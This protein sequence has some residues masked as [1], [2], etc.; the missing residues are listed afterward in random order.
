MHRE[1][2]LD[3]T[4]PGGSG[5]LPVPNP[6]RSWLLPQTSG[7]RVVVVIQVLSIAQS[8]FRNCYLA[9]RMRDFR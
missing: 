7:E 6:G 8:T 4:G 5:R 2:G 1:Q 9:A 3:G